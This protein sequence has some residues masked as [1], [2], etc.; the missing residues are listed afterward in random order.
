MR[1]QKRG[2]AADLPEAIAAL[3]LALPGVRVSPETFRLAKFDRPE[4]ASLG[5]AAHR[6]A[7]G[8]R[9]LGLGVV[10]VSQVDSVSQ[11]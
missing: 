1:R 11:V 3:S 6:A 5:I 10:L 2:Q 7:I 8:K 4:A 9:L